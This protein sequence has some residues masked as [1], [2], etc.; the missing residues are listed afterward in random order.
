MKLVTLAAGGAECAGLV[1]DRKVLLLGAASEGRLEVPLKEILGR[2]EL[3]E[4]VRA[5]AA[6]A[7]R[8]RRLSQRYSIGLKEPDLLAPI[9][10]P[11]KV[12]CLGLNY[13]DH[14]AESGAAVPAEPVIF[15]KASSSVIGPHRPIRIPKTSDQ[16]DYEVELAVVIG[17]RAKNVTAQYAMAH[18]A[19]YTVL[20]DVTARDYQRVRGGGQWTLSK[21]FDTFCPLGPWIVTADE[22][23]DPQDL[24]LECMVG[25]EKMQSSSTAQMIF[26]I[27]QI[28][29]YLSAVLT[30]EPGDVIGTGTPPGVG[31]ARTPPRFLRA[32]EVVECTVEKIGTLT[33]PVE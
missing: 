8:R 16:I 20:N 13:R 29:E 15:S 18:V 28:I 9:P 22:I 21:S 23:P 3:L 33:N 1:I 6:R 11:G 12:L 32:G 7:E 26:T 5:L 27:P 31:F 24:R 30:L 4:E 2:P 14:A 25:G 17:L 19:G 10:R